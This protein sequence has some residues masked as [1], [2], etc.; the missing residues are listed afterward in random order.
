ME[1]PVSQQ[2]KLEVTKIR[3]P[4][5]SGKAFELKKG[6]QL[7]VIC[8]DGEQVSDMVCFDNNDLENRLSNG[9]TF[10]YE[11]CIL[12]TEGNYLWSNKSDK[13]LKILEDTCGI[14]DFLLAPCD[15]KTFEIIYKDK[16]PRP[17]CFKNLY[18][19]LKEFGIDES[20]IPTAFNIFMNVPFDWQ[21]KITV[22]PPKAQAGD[23]IIFEAQM[24]LIVGL[25]ACSAEQSNNQKFKPIDYEVIES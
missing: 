12:L 7:K 2:P 3:I 13:M 6:Q 10:D 18:E 4:I 17:S 15:K 23:Y 5:Q 16:T 9:K 1:M 20:H 21:G 11:E 8:P 24:D 25:T 14:H 19:N 22:E